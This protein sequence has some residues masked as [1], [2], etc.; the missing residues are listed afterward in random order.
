MC[1]PFHT[2]LSWQHST[3]RLHRGLPPRDVSLC[4]LVFS[5]TVQRKAQGFPCLQE[6]SSYPGKG[7]RGPSSCY[8]CQ[9]VD[10]ATEI[11]LPFY[12]AL[13]KIMVRSGLCSKKVTIQERQG[14]EVAWS[15]G[16]VSQQQKGRRSPGFLRLRSVPGGPA[17]IISHIAHISI[18]CLPVFISHP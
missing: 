14:D 9:Q 18:Y 15:T 13:P 17:Q 6:T 10:S 1:V 8:L 12:Q 16:P 7:W 5:G 2:V 3:A 4:L 11:G